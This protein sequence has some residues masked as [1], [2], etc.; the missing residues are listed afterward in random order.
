MEVKLSASGRLPA[1]GRLLAAAGVLA[2]VEEV[3]QDRRLLGVVAHELRPH[4]HDG[5]V[6]PA[7]LGDHRRNGLGDLGRVGR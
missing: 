5:R 6:D 1:S 4:R 2:R 7:Q 3:A